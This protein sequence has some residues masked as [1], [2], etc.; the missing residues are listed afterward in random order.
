MKPSRLAMAALQGK[1]GESNFSALIDQATRRVAA[2]QQKVRTSGASSGGTTQWKLSRLFH[3]HRSTGIGLALLVAA[4]TITAQRRQNAAWNDTAARLDAAEKQHYTASQVNA[5]TLKH[6][7]QSVDV[8]SGELLVLPQVDRPARLKDWIQSCF[9]RALA[10]TA[11]NP[12]P[13][14]S[15][16]DK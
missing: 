2:K 5:Q 1:E 3:Y 14:D 7:T 16:I 10:P 9:D 11:N 13:T 6:F 4:T 15:I 12:S 8:V